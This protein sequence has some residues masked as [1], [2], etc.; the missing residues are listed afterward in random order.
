MTDRGEYTIPENTYVPP[1]IRTDFTPAQIEDLQYL[2]EAAKMPSW[3]LAGNCPDEQIAL[4]AGN[5]ARTVM[6][7]ARI[8]VQEG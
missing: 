4:N 6:M 8:L 5:L 7:I 1:K 2:I 3:L